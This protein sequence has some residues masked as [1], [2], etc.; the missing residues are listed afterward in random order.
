MDHNLTV[1]FVPIDAVGHV[2]ACVGIA[3][4]LIQAG[5]RVVF[6][7]SDQWRGRLTKY[8]IQE[9][10]LTEEGRDGSVDPGREWAERF[11]SD[12]V[13]KKGA[14]AL[15]NMINVMQN[16]MPY[17]FERQVLLDKKLES[18]L[19]TIKPDVMFLDQL[20]ELPSVL[21]SK[22]PWVLVNSCNPLY[23]FYSDELPP[24]I[25]D[26]MWG[27]GSVP[28]IQVL[29]LVDLVITHG[30]NN[31]VT[32]TMYFGKPMIVLPLLGDQWDNAQRVE[33]KGFGIRLDAYKCSEE[34]LLNA[35]QSLLNNKELNEMLLKISQR[36]QLDNSIASLPEMIEKLVAKMD[37]NNN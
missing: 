9:I 22:I 29:P 37:I 15:D 26:N 27:E 20:I 32:E 33:D 16:T 7:V 35:I 2:N 24:A 4:V 1:L 5:H 25:S 28:Q 17:L 34:E 8:G 23:H 31:T 12:G 21:K 11:V 3:E 13:I 14:T 10:L 6:V 19:P 18:L 36:I 30:G